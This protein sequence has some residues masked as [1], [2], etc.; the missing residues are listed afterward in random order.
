MKL[1]SEDL[2]CILERYMSDEQSYYRANPGSGFWRWGWVQQRERLAAVA[3]WCASKC[4]GSIV[5][6][7][8]QEGLT[9]KLLGAV[10]RK[11][12]RRVIAVDSWIPGTSGCEG[13]EYEKFLANIELYQ[14][15]I[16]V[17]RLP[18]D[19]VRVSNRLVNEQLCFAY[20]DAL[21][22]TVA[23]AQDIRIVSHA[24]CIA[25][26]DI[27]WDGAVLVAYMESFRA[28]LHVRHPYCREGYLLGVQ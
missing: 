14:D 5:E 15:I 27:L 9:T 16:E 22:T 25:V 18:S 20:V 17:L 3:E 1:E 7:G 11:H 2:V 13:G 26:D 23:C 6:I 19:D 28:R 8:C 12:N 24:S 10:A 21:H 4:E